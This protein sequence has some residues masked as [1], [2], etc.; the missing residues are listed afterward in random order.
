MSSSHSLQ[1][2]RAMCKI[3]VVYGSVPSVT[4]V[5]KILSWIKSLRP[6]SLQEILEAKPSTV[7]M[8]IDTQPPVETYEEAYV[9]FI[10]QILSDIEIYREELLTWYKKDQVLCQILRGYIRSVQANYQGRPTILINGKRVEPT[11]VLI[12]IW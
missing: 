7:V 10:A 11:A 6:I 9:H 12:R 8:E 5:Q 3:T 1:E 4:H 2:V